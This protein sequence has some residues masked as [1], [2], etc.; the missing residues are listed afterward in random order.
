MQS[1]TM[2]GLFRRY[3]ITLASLVSVSVLTI[4]SIL[5]LNHYFQ[6]QQRAHE[7]QTA[8][9]RAAAASIDAYLRG[10]EGVLRPLSRRLLEGTAVGR[11]A[12]ARDF[13]DALK[14][15]PAI[16]NIRSLDARF[17]ETNFVSRLDADRLA[18]G[19]PYPGNQQLL[20]H[21]ASAFCYGP[22]FV[23]D[24]TEPYVAV[25]VNDHQGGDTLVAEISVRFIDDLLAKL[26]I[27]KAGR[28]YVVDLNG[29]LLAHPDLRTLLRR[30]D[31][32]Q[33]PQ[34]REV[35]SAL[36]QGRA[37]LPSVWGESP[38]GGAVFSSATRISGPEWVLYV[39]Q[40]A[41]EILRTVWA[42]I[43][44]TMLVLA[45][46]IAAASLA[47]LLLA[48]RL[49]KPILQ[50][51]DGA[52]KLGSGDLSA[53]IDVQSRDEIQSVAI[54]FNGMADS[55]RTLYESLE[56]KVLER[57]RDLAQAN[58]QITTQAR[59][60]SVLN[61]KLG[62]QLQELNVKRDAA[63]RASAAKTRFVAAASHDL[64]QP[65]HA[66]G[67]LVGILAD[68]QISPEIGALLTK[69]QLSVSALENLFET[70]LD[71]SKLDAGIVAP[72]LTCVSLDSLLESV[73]L[74]HSQA[75]VAKG[76][77][78]RVHGLRTLVYTDSALLFS[79]L[80]NLV[81]NAIRY[82]ERGHVDVY[83]RKRG[84]LVTVFVADTGIGIPTVELERIFEE[85]YQLPDT[86]RSRG[87]GLGLGL[88]IV[89]RTAELLGY[90]LSAR[91]TI[92]VGSVFGIQ[93]PIASPYQFRQMPPTPSYGHDPVLAGA[94]I[95]V[96]D[97][98][99][100]SRFATE[101]IF[102]SWRC[103]VI[104]GSCGAAVRH[105]LSSHLRQPD[106]IVAD[107][108]LGNEETGL[109]VIQDL[110]RDAEMS[111]PAIILTADHDVARAATAKA[112]DIVF[113]QKP[114]NA[115]RIRRIVME[116]IPRVVNAE[117]QAVSSE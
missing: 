59:E 85:F 26:S 32:S 117:H 99:Q 49:T 90:Q 96:V 71:I 102:K 15:E 2:K 10:I 82:T 69:I 107:Y 23:R 16:L 93:S 50:L 19:A 7:V 84:S 86:S 92:G 62:V 78:L 35:K 97:D 106:L 72:H 76:L 42:T 38:N 3:V 109:A 41:N 81:S 64:R 52:Q 18:S 34:I 91:S 40:P 55:L 83:C 36:S 6:D 105:E 24:Q 75:A 58:E 4:G 53:K 60:L 79:M 68:R 57:T 25:S 65:M 56:S 103:H 27:G 67:L 87:Q 47:A 45:L 8:G 95:V 28:A 13:R 113:L 29:R 110:R 101:A 80:G 104:A 43:G 73:E 111:I 98:D 115:Q 39:E 48:R 20:Q 1:A 54:A 108:W 61:D 12:Q 33:L 17:L 77:T 44:V 5:A 88:A 31:V 89:R 14:F 11:T 22:I 37:E 66:V 9:A 21:C 46:G 116:L 112:C 100:D 94:F 63:D 114:A 51:R 70:L 74:S 30:S